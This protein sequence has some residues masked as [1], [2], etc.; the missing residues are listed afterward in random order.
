MRVLL[1]IIVSITVAI[2]IAKIA[3]SLI[4]IKTAITKNNASYKHSKMNVL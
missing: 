3:A 2:I 1:L 4:V